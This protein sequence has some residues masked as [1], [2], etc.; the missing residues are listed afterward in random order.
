MGSSL[1]D[2][3][4]PLD[5]W[6]GNP[7]GV[8]GAP[9]LHREAFGLIAAYQAPRSEMEEALALIWSS[10]L[11]ID[12]VGVH[13][14]LFELGGNSLLALQLVSEVNKAIGITVFSEELFASF[15][16]ANHA[17]MA[18]EALQDFVN[19]LSDAEI[20]RLLEIPVNVR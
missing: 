20:E 6:A 5:L 2:I 3:H 18:E 15:T 11:N 16:V 1:S 7:A 12:Q 4:A 19:S 14:G 10:I 17:A 8:S 13:D 9:R